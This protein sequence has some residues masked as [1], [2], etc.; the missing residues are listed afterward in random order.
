MRKV[1]IEDQYGNI[2][3]INEEDKDEFYSWCR[4]ITDGVQDYRLTCKFKACKI[5]SIKNLIIKD[6][7]LNG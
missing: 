1:I 3:L 4:E 5:K 7:S 6:Y 2:Y